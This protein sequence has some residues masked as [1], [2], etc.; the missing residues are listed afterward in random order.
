MS[1]AIRIPVEGAPEVIDIDLRTSKAP[2]EIIGGWIEQVTINTDV[3]AYLDVA[4]REVVMLVDEEGLVKAR[5][6]NR[7]ATGFYTGDP[8]RGI[9]CGPALLVGQEYSDEGYDW[10]GL[11]GTVTPEQVEKASAHAMRQAGVAWL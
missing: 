3:A 4:Q 10:A 7:T 1:R 11:P 8:R 5:D 2:Q 9:I 6:I